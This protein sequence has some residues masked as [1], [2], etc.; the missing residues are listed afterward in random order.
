VRGMAVSACVH[1][2]HADGLLEEWGVWQV[3]PGCQRVR[4]S[5]RNGQARKHRQVWPRGRES[6]RA[7]EAVG[8]DRAG[9]SGRERGRSGTQ[10]GRA[11]PNGPKGR[12]KGGVVCF[13]FSFFF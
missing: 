5:A 8:A 11:G 12:V 10:H 4:I 3:G 9:P 2:A 7:G 1:A 6:E 13:R